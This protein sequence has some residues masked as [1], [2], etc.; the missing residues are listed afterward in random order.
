V[1]LA[2]KLAEHSS[3]TAHVR[4]LFYVLVGFGTRAIRRRGGSL[5]RGVFPWTGSSC[6]V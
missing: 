1:D 6:V 3:T 2:L 4:L 5:E